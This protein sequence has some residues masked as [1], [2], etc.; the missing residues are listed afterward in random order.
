LISRQFYP[1][2]GVTRAGNADK[3]SWLRTRAELCIVQISRQIDE[4]YMPIDLHYI[5]KRGENY[6]YLGADTFE[7]GNW[8]ATNLLSSLAEGGRIFLHVAQKEPAWIG[9]TMLR[10]R[11]APSPENSRKIFVCR[12]DFDYKI[13]CHALWGREKAIARWNDERTNLMTER[14]YMKVIKSK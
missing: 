11:S 12:R 4:Q 3:S 13:R 14:E 8:V 6:K 5:C 9:G 7:T 10:Y 2:K 1:V